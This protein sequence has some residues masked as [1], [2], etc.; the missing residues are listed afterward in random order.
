MRHNSRDRA[1]RSRDDSRASSSEPLVSCI[2]IF[3][4][5]EK[6]LAEAVESV[7]AQTYPNWELLLV[8]DDSSDGSGAIARAYCENQPE[9]IR[10]LTHEGAVNRGMSASRNL[11]IREARGPLVALLDGDDTWLPK[12]LEQQI[13]LFQR[14]PEAV[15]VCG[16]TLYWHSWQAD[17]EEE[18][19]LVFI[20]DNTP[21]GLS[22][23][24]MEQDRLYEPMDLLKRLYP[25]GKGASPSTSSLI[26]RREM[27]LSVGCFEESFPGLFEDQAFMVKAYLAGPIYVSRICVNFYRQHSESCCYVMTATGQSRAARG[28]FLEWMKNYL[29]G[30]GCRD[31]V[32]RSK[33]M[34]RVARNNYPRA[35]RLIVRMTRLLNSAV[36]RLRSILP[37]RQFH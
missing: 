31:P 22:P 12:K 35:Y 34:L 28:R 18:D 7:L 2:I 16:A 23:E 32:V 29:D 33:L 1:E 37:Q 19:A 27:A 11:G 20:G 9:R 21:D 6:F 25:L 24:S 26:F 13:A 3:L 4:N 8:D 5:E 17:Q 36:P 10:Y 15:M 14:Y 30:V